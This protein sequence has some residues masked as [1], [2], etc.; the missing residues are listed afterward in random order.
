MLSLTIS[1]MLRRMTCNRLW[2]KFRR[3]VRKQV[4]RQ[5]I[6]L[7]LSTDFWKFTQTQNTNLQTWINYYWI[8]S[9]ITIFKVIKSHKWWRKSG[10]LQAWVDLNLSPR[11]ILS[12]V[13]KLWPI[14][15][16]SWACVRTNQVSSLN[17]NIEFNI[18]FKII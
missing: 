12:K 4:S 1:K 14:N 8:I 13:S 3:K 5:F 6:W 16:V 2:S 11:A 15:Q 18:N 17:H 7:V 9:W 10:N